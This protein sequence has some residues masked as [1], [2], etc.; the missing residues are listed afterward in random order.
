MMKQLGIWF[1]TE[2]RPGW[3]PFNPAFI[4]ALILNG[5]LVFAINAGLI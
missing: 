2:I 3:H 4:L 5:A 1:L